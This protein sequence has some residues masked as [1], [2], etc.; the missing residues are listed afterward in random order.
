M[1]D[2]YKQ[3][4][5]VA[6]KHALLEKKEA[7]ATSV[8]TNMTLHC[9]SDFTELG[10]EGSPE[11]VYTLSISSTGGKDFFRGVSDSDES[12]KLEEAVKNDLRRA[13]RK[14]DKHI[15]LILE[16]YKLQAR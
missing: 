14:F 16:K 7:V 1:K 4:Q 12:S 11:V 2:L 5:E 6:V 3:L 15:E 8:N 9:N 10:E 13:I